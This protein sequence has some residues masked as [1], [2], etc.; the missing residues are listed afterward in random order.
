MD[1]KTNPYICCLQEPH[2]TSRDTYKLKVRGWK[3]IFFA[4]G[5]QKKAG[6]A[7]PISYKI[8][9]K[10]K[11]TLRDREEHYIIIKGSIQEDIRILNIYASNVG[12]PQC[13]R[14]LLT[15]LKG[16]INSNTIRVWDFNTHLLQWTDHS[17][18][19]SIRKHRP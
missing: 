4:I 17:D 13:I 11:N 8:H 6:V 15:T 1:T 2:F 19:K 5:N 14:Q 12:S 10:R 9:I 18:R 3:K 7:L 16:E